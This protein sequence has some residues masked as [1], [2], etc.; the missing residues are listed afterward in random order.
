MK[1][2]K[3]V[4][5]LL[6]VV[7]VA[8][9][10]YVATRPNDYDVARSKVIKA[11]VDVVFNNINDYKNWEAW[12]PWM[13]EDPSIEISYNEQTSGIGANYSWTSKDGPG[14]M[15]TT[16]LTQNKSIEQEMQFGDYE[17]TTVSWEFEEV[18]EGTKVTWRMQNEKTPFIFKLFAV[19]SGG[20]DKMLGEM[21]EKGLENL[22]KVIAEHM[23]KNPPQTGY[24]LGEISQMDFEAKQFAGYYQKTSTE[25]TVEEMGKL[26]Q[27][28]MPKA[29]MYGA[30]NQL[31]YTPGT[32]YT[33][34]DEET[35]EAEFYIGLMVHST[36]KLPTADGLTITPMKAGK[37]VKISKFGPYGVGDMEAHQEI[38]KFL[39]Q[40]KLV[41][42]GP[43]WEQFENDPMEVKPKDIQTDIYY[44]VTAAK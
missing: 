43:V 10:I 38:A 20:M 35:K 42:A 34:W 16:S 25:A 6:L 36:D 8:G 39:E 5:L 7:I 9:A 13:E 23:K 14:K 11:P 28:H 37:V 24:R 40:H 32:L 22:D 27:T 33:K 18:E 4:L 21:E 29:G 30:T 2:L 15:K 1:I 41:P 26:F 3:Y 31:E 17:P 12:G 19:L 44:L